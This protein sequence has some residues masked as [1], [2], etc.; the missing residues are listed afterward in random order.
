EVDQHDAVAA[1]DLLE[2]AHGQRLGGHHISDRRLRTNRSTRRAGVTF[3][4]TY[5]VSGATAKPAYRGDDRRVSGSTLVFDG[6]CGF[7]TATARF[8]ERR[9]PTSA[10]VVPWQR[11][12]LD[13]VG[14]TREQCT[15]A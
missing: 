15:E 9:I 8:I 11:L 5:L 12:D 3:P 4:G 14:L 7:C 10:R 6:D 1:G 13:D 2:V